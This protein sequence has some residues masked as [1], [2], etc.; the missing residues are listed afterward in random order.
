MRG[1]GIWTWHKGH[2]AAGPWMLVQKINFLHDVTLVT[3]LSLLVL[4]T[5][6]LLPPPVATHA[7]SLVAP[8]TG[9]LLDY[10]RMPQVMQSAGYFD[11]FPGTVLALI[12]TGV[13]VCTSV[14]GKLGE[15]HHTISMCARCGVVR[16]FGSALRL[17]SSPRRGYGIP[18]GTTTSIN[19]THALRGL[20]KSTASRVAGV[21]VQI[22][23]NYP[24]IG[25]TLSVQTPRLSYNRRQPPLA[26][27]DPGEDGNN[28]TEASQ[29]P[30][31]L[32]I[33]Q[34]SFGTSQHAHVSAFGQMHENVRPCVC[35]Y[36]CA[37][38][39]PADADCCC[40][41]HVEGRDARAVFV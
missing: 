4:A 15:P 31:L 37:P 33:L 3:G 8:A 27:E 21:Q 34:H 18:T 1:H 40:R 6:E 29:F 10:S 25:T 16:E 24:I 9:N 20:T 2:Q 38:V 35:L 39:H 14:Q 19:R 17:S 30:L 22:S 7:R 12:S 32:S 28:P 26:D 41:Q 36:V 11:A 5:A 13:L 23:Q